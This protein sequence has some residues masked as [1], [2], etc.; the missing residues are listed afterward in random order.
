MTKKTTSNFFPVLA[1]AC[2]NTLRQEHND[3]ST[4]KTMGF[5]AG[6][7]QQIQLALS[8]AGFET[9]ESDESRANLAIVNCIKQ[10]KKGVDS[11][12]MEVFLKSDFII[13]C[14]SD[15]F[16]FGT[17]RKYKELRKD[18]ILNGYVFSVVSIPQGALP[19]TKDHVSF[20]TLSHKSHACETRFLTAETITSLLSADTE[21]REK[22]EAITSSDAPWAIVS[23]VSYLI[24]T[25]RLDAQFHCPTAEQRKAHEY[26]EHIA[27][28]R[29][30]NIVTF[31]RPARIEKSECEDRAMILR[32]DVEDLANGGYTIPHEDKKVFIK[33]TG[34]KDS[35]I[36][37]Y[38]IVMVLKG[39]VGAV[40]LIG[41]EVKAIAHENIIILRLSQDDDI[42][43]R[44]IALFQYLRSQ[45]SQAYL[46]R[47]SCLSSTTQT[48]SV[49][50]IK[51][52]PVP[53]NYSDNLEEAVSDFDRECQLTEQ[54]NKLEKERKDLL[55]RHWSLD[56]FS[57]NF[58][59][60]FLK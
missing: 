22:I 16:L 53:T 47:Y 3:I 32:L 35:L 25:N 12:I 19:S 24:D 60:N 21:P 58:G 28:T 2:A 30:D 48:L 42:K 4:V 33:Q 46:S 56:Q 14:V 10:G 41:L 40:G 11:L 6:M 17:D 29:L 36:H 7:T 26:L 9:V 50:D 59:N 18:L 13:C 20:I 43:R 34:K 55:G 1:S 45:L 8:S 54:I 5:D 57:A 23:E 31:L 52:L 37:K 39:K 27:T 15:V 44:S 51:Q 49:D 38:D